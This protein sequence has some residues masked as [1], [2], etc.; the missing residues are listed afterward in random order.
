MRALALDVGSRRIGLALSD[1]TALIATPRGVLTRR[2]GA[3]DRDAVRQLVEAEGVDTLVVGHPVA[4]DGGEGRAA[5]AARA[6]GEALARE[7]GL[8]L[9]LWDERMT[10]VESEAT[11]REL[12]YSRR[13][14]RQRID[15]MAA[16]LILQE[17]LD[18]RRRSAG[19][20]H[21]CPSSC[22]FNHKRGARPA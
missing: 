8:I 5:Q 21:Q 22:S 13:R 6:L 2:G 10:T 12:G 9:V 18:S 16:C 14:R 15:S 17:Y 1:P 4:P 19:T 7:L 11:L 20:A 3:H